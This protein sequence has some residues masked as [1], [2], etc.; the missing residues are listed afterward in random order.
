MPGFIN[1]FDVSI[2]NYIKDNMHSRLMDKVMVIVTTLG[3]SGLIWILIAVSLLF[4]KKYRHIGIT[5][6]LVLLINAI[7]G[8]VILKNLFQ[9][10]RPCVSFPE[11]SLLIS[12]PLSYSFPSGHAASSFAAAGVLA[13]YF[14]KYAVGFYAFAA[15]IAFSRMYLYVH[16]PTDVIAGAILGLA[17]SK[18]IPYFL[19]KRFLINLARS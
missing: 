16:Y 17:C 12:R 10:A 13:K 3:N 4:F 7:L 1:N 11:V 9:R 15:L 6:L 8:E 19:N 18:A 5:A 2:L 14:K